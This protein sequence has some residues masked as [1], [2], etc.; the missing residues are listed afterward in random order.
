MTKPFIYVASPY[1]KGNQAINTYFQCKVFDRLMSD[2]IVVPFTPLWSHFQHTIIPQPYEVW[3]EYDHYLIDNLPFDA[4]LRLNAEYEDWY[5]EDESKGAD[6]EEA[7]FRGK[8][9][10][11]FYSVEELY[12]WVNNKVVPA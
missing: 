12:E 4:C 9:T 11:I 6:A 2:G 7:R 3:M 10:P 8:G 1:T 5:Y